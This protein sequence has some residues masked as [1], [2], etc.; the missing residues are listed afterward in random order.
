[1]LHGECVLD[2]LYV[3]CIRQEYVLDMVLDE[4]CSGMSDSA[5]VISSMFLN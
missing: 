1:M 4:L 3:L 5:V 2:E